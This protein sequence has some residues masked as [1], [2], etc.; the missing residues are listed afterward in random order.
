MSDCRPLWFNHTEGTRKRE[1]RKK[2]GKPG[3]CFPVSN[4]RAG[5]CEARRGHYGPDLVS[6]CGGSEREAVWS[7]GARGPD[8]GPPVL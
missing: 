2:K 3:S 7:S 5:P 1:E 6:T 4:T 8:V